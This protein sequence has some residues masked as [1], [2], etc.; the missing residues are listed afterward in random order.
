M[1]FINHEQVAPACFHHQEMY[2]SSCC[3]NNY[4]AS[5]WACN[6][7]AV[8]LMN[9]LRQSVLHS[10]MAEQVPVDFVVSF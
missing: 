8:R 7:Y 5:F 2:V 10:G 9:E 4:V 6:Q 3:N 1:Y